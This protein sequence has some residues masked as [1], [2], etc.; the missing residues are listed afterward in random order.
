MS[1]VQFLRF[2]GLTKTEAVVTNVA[3]ATFQRC[4]KV[5]VNDVGTVLVNA[6]PSESW[7]GSGRAKRTSWHSGCDMSPRQ[8]DYVNGRGRISHTRV[9][10]G[11]RAGRKSCIS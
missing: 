7:R 6:R 4:S 10:R 1:R 5:P 9:A 3:E 8:R 11:S 2:A